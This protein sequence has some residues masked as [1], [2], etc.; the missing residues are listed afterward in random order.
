MSPSPLIGC[1]R[2]ECWIVRPGAGPEFVCL[3]D[4]CQIT[5]RQAPARAERLRH[6]L[7]RIAGPRFLPYQQA[8]LDEMEANRGRVLLRSSWPAAGRAVT[9]LP[10]LVF[11]ARPAHIIVT[12]PARR[13]GLHQ[14]LNEA[15]HIVF[16][17]PPACYDG[18]HA[19]L[20]S[21]ERIAYWLGGR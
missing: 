7:G 15:M 17:L 16:A 13:V 20:R 9:S 14:A 18:A 21:A 1:Q 8:F 3:V 10:E 12:Q 6:G 19:I 5:E 11:E 4:E 2:A